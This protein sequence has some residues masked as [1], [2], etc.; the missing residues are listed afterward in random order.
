MTRILFATDSVHAAAAGVDYL[1]SRDL[2]PD[3][4]AVV[5]LAVH[6]DRPRDAGDALNVVQARLAG[7]IAR[8][9][10]RAGEPGPAVLAV[11]SEADVDEILLSFDGTP[12]T[13][14]GPTSRILAGADRPVVVLP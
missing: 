7:L 11:A 8:R 13:D 3:A 5:A 4:D 2:D 9:E 12:A 14:D 6:P 1:D 10:Q